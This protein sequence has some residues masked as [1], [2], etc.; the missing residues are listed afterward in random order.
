M[1]FEPYNLDLHGVRL[2]VIDIS[3]EEKEKLGLKPTNNNFEYLWAL[4]DKGFEDKLLNNK[5]DPKKSQEYANRRKLEME[6]FKKL[7][8]VDYIL[9]VYD[10]LSWCKKE[11]I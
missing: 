4:C 10:V 3:N 6:T 9:L 11:E 2:P 8:L 7:N 1:D 5:I